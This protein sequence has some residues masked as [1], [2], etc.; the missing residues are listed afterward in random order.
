MP[1]AGLVLGLALACAAPAARATPPDAFA[2]H[3]QLFGISA[4]T[5]FLLRSSS[6]N[7]GLYATDRR[8]VALVLV[9]RATGRE[10]LLPVYGSFRV[11]NSDNHPNS[12][13]TAIH[14]DI[15]TG[16]VDP[17]AILRDHAGEVIMAEADPLPAPIGPIPANLP[18]QVQQR[19]DTYAALMGGYQRMG[20]R[21][22]PDLVAGAID[23]IPCRVDHSLT[24]P[25][26]SATTPAALIRV[27]CGTAKTDDFT[28]SVHLLLPPG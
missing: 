23:N 24:L 27:S 25:E 5:V 6:D 10:S 14:P 28:A 1:R 19:L 12:A 11:P 9:D 17:F 22:L 8:R 7:L 18:K 20:S 26:Q 4:G 13:R 15:P 21:S 3:D 2:L 16:A